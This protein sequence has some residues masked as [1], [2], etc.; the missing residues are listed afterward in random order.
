[1]VS[2]FCEECRAPVSEMAKFCLKCGART[3]RRPTKSFKLLSFFFF[4][5]AGAMIATAVLPRLGQSRAKKADGSDAVRPALQRDATVLA[6]SF[7]SESD[8][9]IQQ[10]YALI[11][12]G[13]RDGAAA[14]VLRESTLA[15]RAGTVVHEYNHEGRLSHVRMASSDSKSK[16]C[17]IPTIMLRAED[18]RTAGASHIPTP[19]KS[20]AS[21]SN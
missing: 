9:Q 7:C 12:Q 1:M 2:V 5:L 8:T 11:A 20:S 10:L 15:V 4:V 14:L 3:G 13:N 16:T 17:W 6:D 19:V 18:H 21:S